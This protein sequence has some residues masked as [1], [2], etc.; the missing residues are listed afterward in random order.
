MPPTNTDAGLVD[1]VSDLAK[2]DR[3]R[4]EFGALRLFAVLAA[5]KE[6]RY[7]DWQAQGRDLFDKLFEAT[8]QSL[9]S[10]HHEPEFLARPWL[11]ERVKYYSLNQHLAGSVDQLG[12]EVGKGFGILFGD[13]PADSLSR[14]G[15]GV[16][17]RAFEQTLK[18]HA[19][20]KLV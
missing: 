9:M 16:F 20:F 12:T 18:R 19:D 6:S 17:F 11:A 13:P 15:R 2:A 10:E 8:L 1:H 3:F 5:T 7:Q 14:L 4:R